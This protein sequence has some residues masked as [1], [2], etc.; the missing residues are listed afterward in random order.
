MPR[1]V[2]RI[3]VASLSACLLA[4]LLAPERASA[5]SLEIE[6]GFDTEVIGIEEAVGFWIEVRSGYRQPPDFEPTFELDNLEPIGEPDRA[7]S[8]SFLGGS[9]H[10]TLRF[11][12]LLR[13]LSTGLAAV[14][15]I[16]VR[17]RGETFELPTERLRVQDEAPPR[18]RYRYPPSS[19]SRGVE[20]PTRRRPELP[21]P[22]PG[23]PTST[24][25]FLRAEIEPPDPWVGQQILYTLYLYTQA[26]I[27]S[28]YPRRVP[29]FHGFWAHE[30]ELARP[31]STEMVD[32]DGE[33]YGRVPLLKRVLF[34][35]RPG[36][37]DLEP[38]EYDLVARMRRPGRSGSRRERPEQIT[39]RGNPA[40]LDVRPLPSG[41]P[42]FTGAVGRFELSARLQ[43]SQVSAGEA[44]TL[45]VTLQGNGHVQSLPA[46]SPPELPGVTTYPA[47]ETGTGDIERDGLRGER[48]WR[49]VLVPRQKGRWPL[50]EMTL[51]YF[52]P[53][54]GGYRVARASLPMLVARPS[55]PTAA[56]PSPG[57]ELHPIRSAAI[58]AEET[59]DV[60][61]LLPWLATLPLLLALV[62]RQVQRRKSGGPAARALLQRL[63][64]IE[65]AGDGGSLAANRHAA[66]RIEESWRSYLDERWR[67][68]PETPS[69]RWAE[70]LG[71][72]PDPAPSTARAFRELAEEI[73]YLRFAPQL[74]TTD[75]LRRELLE[76]SRRMAR[77]LP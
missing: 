40:T 9:P 71:K 74:S 73:H 4:A 65:T 42:E 59:P 77:R 1:I 8:Y 32:V 62:L 51:T 48:S 60:R 43:P 5:Q 64:E 29:S 25:V 11:T 33:R 37:H 28:I 66:S 24:S 38:A 34:P 16:R 67:I 50:Q 21:T 13:P 18:S 70:A 52:D 30:V 31:S 3:V 10:R 63:D 46:P 56:L 61:R 41:P 47:E 75:T 72:R 53:E 35:R 23:P 26:D 19:P 12:W 20:P 45:T 57:G 44:A 76:R 58:P 68:P 36:H 27:D 17:I 7:E 54:A 55:S 14:R 6:A 22:I 49:F 39:R 69:T 15:G 2:P